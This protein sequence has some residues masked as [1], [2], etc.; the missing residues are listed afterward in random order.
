[1]KVTSASHP[2]FVDYLRRERSIDPDTDVESANA[3]RTV[4]A[5]ERTDTHRKS[6]GNRSL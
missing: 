3:S 4:L 2:C 1:V 5:V 6:F